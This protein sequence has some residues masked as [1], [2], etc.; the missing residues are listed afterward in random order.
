MT[1]LVHAVYKKLIDENT[2]AIDVICEFAAFVLVDGMT[3]VRVRA[4]HGDFPGACRQ[5]GR[6]RLL[7]EFGHELF[8]AS[9]GSAGS[10]EDDE[11][12]D[13]PRPSPRVR[14]SR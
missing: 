14:P 13:A 12:V 4:L 5:H 10:M 8:H 6:G 2:Y 9:F 7:F 1:V 3:D 11:G